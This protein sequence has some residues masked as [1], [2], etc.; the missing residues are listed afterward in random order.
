L[1]RSCGLAHEKSCTASELRDVLHKVDCALIEKVAHVLGDLVPRTPR[2]SAKDQAY[3][4]EQHQDERRKRED[5]VDSLG[6]RNK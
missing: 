1:G 3:D 4:R 5:S 6:N 2:I